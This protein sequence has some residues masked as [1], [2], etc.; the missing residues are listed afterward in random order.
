LNTLP[1]LSLAAILFASQL[2]VKSRDVAVPENLSL[3]DWFEFWAH[4]GEPISYRFDGLRESN[5]L[6]G[7][8]TPAA[9]LGDYQLLHFRARQQM[10][11][12]EQFRRKHY[13]G[14][15]LYGFHALVGRLQIRPASHNTVIFKQ[16]GI[17][18]LDQ[19]FE[20]RTDFPRAWRSIG[21]QGNFAESNDYFR[22]YWFF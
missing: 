16:D 5:A 1:A 21:S 10:R 13:L 19:R 8:R 22:Q 18:V 15:L 20:P 6:G 17:V 4:R 7:P 11:S 3:G 14:K 12:A 2:F 9:T